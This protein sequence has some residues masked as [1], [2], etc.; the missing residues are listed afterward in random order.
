MM[1][2]SLAMR[3][4][5]LRAERGLSLTE[6]AERAG[7]QR[8]TLALL[9]RG[10][11][12]PHDPTLAKIAKGYG[13]PVEDLLDEPVPLG[14]APKASGQADGTKGPDPAVWGPKESWPK[15]PIPESAGKHIHVEVQD[16]LSDEPAR[17]TITETPF[18]DVARE[19]REG[20]LSPETAWESLSA[21]TR[22]AFLDVAREIREGALSPEDAWVRI[23]RRLG[24]EDRERSA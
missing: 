16:D 23:L 12:H 14:E 13:V 2:R 24:T 20:K 10:E 22:T 18:L 7:I 3:L 6:A 4:R 19:I 9:E 21:D 1:R 17:V 5:V 8:Q 11:R 15:P